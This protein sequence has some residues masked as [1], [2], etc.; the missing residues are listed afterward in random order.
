MIPSIVRVILECKDG[1]T[2]V[3]FEKYLPLRFVI[4][5]EISCC[6]CCSGTKISRGNP[7][8]WNFLT[9]RIE[10]VIFPDWADRSVEEA[11]KHYTDCGGV[12]ENR[13]IYSGED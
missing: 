1:I 13:E 6:G 11:A 2:T 4:G 12:E 7:P 10:Y 3:V 8:E 9:G 5:D